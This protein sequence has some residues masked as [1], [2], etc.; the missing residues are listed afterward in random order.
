MPW[1]P[2]D[3]WPPDD[4]RP[5][6]HLRCFSDFWFSDFDFLAKSLKTGFATFLFPMHCGIQTPDQRNAK[7]IPKSRCELSRCDLDSGGG[8]DK[9][10][11]WQKGA[12]LGGRPT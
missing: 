4:V 5:S 1:D 10:A 11:R 6:V 7:V 12:S 8:L 2:G 3:V 9:F